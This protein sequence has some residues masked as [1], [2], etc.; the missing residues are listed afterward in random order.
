MN[1]DFI[2]AQQQQNDVQR[3]VKVLRLRLCVDHSRQ[4]V[5]GFFHENS[6]ANRIRRINSNGHIVMV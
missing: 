2:F 6:Y 5:F 1:L 3:P 4:V